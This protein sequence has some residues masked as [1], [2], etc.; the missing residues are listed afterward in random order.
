ME[1][2]AETSSQAAALI[3]QE[4]I[5][6]DSMEVSSGGKTMQPSAEDSALTEKEASNIQAPMEGV[7]E[8]E[9]SEDEW[10]VYDEL[11]KTIDEV[12]N[13]A[14]QQTKPTSEG[15]LKKYFQ[16]TSAVSIGKDR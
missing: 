8:E 9:E 15:D 4:H 3:G 5:V 7:E 14:K 2:T 16:S 1:L 10:T 11:D 6:K 12:T 13:N